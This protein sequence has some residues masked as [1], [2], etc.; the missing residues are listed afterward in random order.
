MLASFAAMRLLFL[1][2]TDAKKNEFPVV[3][4]IETFIESGIPRLGVV[5]KGSQHDPVALT[6]KINAQVWIAS[7]R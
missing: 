5:L 6:S 7:H 3:I 1:S 2:S 4:D